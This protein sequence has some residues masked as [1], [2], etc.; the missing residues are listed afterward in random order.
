M[1]SA[2]ALYLFSGICVYAALHH[3]LAARRQGFESANA[4]FAAMSA[5]A[6]G[7]I[8]TLAMTYQA[9]TIPQFVFAHKWNISFI[10]AMYMIFPW[11]VSRLTGMGSTPWLAATSLAFAGVLAWNAL[12]P[13]GL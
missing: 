11:F 5:S 9:E 10:A 1:N 4:W 12:Q 8:A 6:A 3:L 2:A 7:F 13:F